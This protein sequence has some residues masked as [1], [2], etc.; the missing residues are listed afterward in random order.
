MD[1]FLSQE[2]YADLKNYFYSLSNT[3]YALDDQVE[4][5]NEIANQVINIKY[6]TAHQLRI[7]MEIDAALPKKLNLPDHIFCS[8]LSNL[9]DN[10][11]EASG[12]IADPAVFVKLHTVKNYLSIT[13]KNRIEPWQHESA[14]NHKT[15]KSKPHLHGLGLRIVEETVQSYN[16][17]SSYE[18]IGQEY[19]ASI[20]LEVF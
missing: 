11:I 20:M 18:I 1:R 10:A 16:G 17:I 4:T 15:T 5:G 12:K 14:K 7:P 9:L 13:V 6:A 2:K 3:L 19:I 8:V